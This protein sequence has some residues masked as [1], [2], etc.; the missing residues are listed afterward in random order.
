MNPQ[1]PDIRIN[2]AQPHG[3]GRY[4][5]ETEYR[6][7]PSAAPSSP[8]VAALRTAAM[9]L[10]NVNT[11]GRGRERRA[12]WLSSRDLEGVLSIKQQQTQRFRVVFRDMS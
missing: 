9:G 12:Y 5:D 4:I 6:P 7:S 8:C 3:P 11:I 10:K 1:A 2:C